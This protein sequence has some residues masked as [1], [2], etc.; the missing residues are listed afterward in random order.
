MRNDPQQIR[1]EIVSLCLPG[2]HTL[3]LVINLNPYRDW[4]SAEE[5]LE[6]L[7]ER[8]WR[9]TIVLFTWGDRLRDTTIEQLIEREGKELQWLVEKCGN[10]YHVLNNKDRGGTQVTELLEK[11]ED[12]VRG[13]YGQYFTTD[14]EQLYTELETYNREIEELRQRL[15]ERQRS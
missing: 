9:H 10:R 13:N 6:L 4:R 1:Q 3:L 12:M 15:E 14:I 2:P 8:V 7:S 11:I 5:H